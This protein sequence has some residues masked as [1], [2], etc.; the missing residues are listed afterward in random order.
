MP[1]HRA[2]P[3][4]MTLNVEGSEDL[5]VKERDISVSV[6]AGNR[7]TALGEGAFGKPGFYVEF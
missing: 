5:A 3:A 7:G 2:V 1:S 4:R 6:L